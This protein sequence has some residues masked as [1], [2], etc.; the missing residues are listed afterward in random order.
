MIFVAVGT[1][2]GQFDRL[3]RRIDEIAPSIKEKIVAQ[4][5]SGSYK[6]KNI[7]FFSFAPTLDEYYR[8]ARV[9]IVQSATSLIEVSMNYQKPVITVPRQKLYGEHINDHQVEFGEFFAK[10]TGIFCFTDVKKITPELLKKYNKIPE[11]ELKNIEKLR[12]SYRAFFKSIAPLGKD[13]IDYFVNLIEPQRT[14]KVLNIG[15]SNI[16]EIEMVLEN[17]VRECWTVDIDSQK[18]KNAALYLH[19]TKLI[20]GD[21]TK[22]N[23]LKRGYYDKIVMCEVLEHLKNDDDVLITLRSLL[24]PGGKLIF[25][26]PNNHF[27]HYLHPVTYMQHERQ[28]TNRAVLDLMAK[29][30]FKIEH[31]NVVECWTLLVNLYIH[32]FYKYFL[33]KSKNFLTFSQRANRSYRQINKSGL[34]IAVRAVKF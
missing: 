9:V 17:R 28:Y 32:L 25:S 13:R 33:G 30:G 7:E 15:V 16:P 6:P 31:F 23:F 3:I 19:R 11:I 5:G 29:T 8:K 21:I 10:K 1:H 22:E 14:D 24:K 34:D 26:V 27:L 18:L 2:D 4:I 12:S 20:E